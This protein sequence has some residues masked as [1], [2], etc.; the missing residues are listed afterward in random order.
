MEPKDVTEYMKAVGE[1]FKPLAEQITGASKQLFTYALR[2]N[3][4][5]CVGEVLALAAA[6]F[7]LY[8]AYR[9]CRWGMT[10]DNDGRAPFDHGN[11]DF[12]VKAFCGA[13]LFFVTGVLFLIAACT[14]CGDAVPRMI[15]PEWRTL[16][17]I[18]ATVRR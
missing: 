2:H 4:A 15:A 10:K 5:V 14:F 9:Y 7:G 16:Q 3:Y 11:Y 17:D 8:S 1:G 6:S 12:P 18:I 13:S